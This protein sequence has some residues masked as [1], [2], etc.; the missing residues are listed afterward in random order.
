M[1][2]LDPR[3]SF[4]DSGAVTDTAGAEP[5]EPAGDTAD[6]PTSEA[7]DPGAGDEAPGA[8][9]ETAALRDRVETLASELEALR[10]Q[11]EAIAGGLAQA[12]AAMHSHRLP[13]S[14]VFAGEAVP[15]DRWDVAERLER[16][17]YMSL[18]SP[19][20][21]ILWLKRSARY[22]PYIETELRRAGLPD[23]LKYVAVVESALLPRAYSW[24]HASGIWQFIADTARRYGLRVT[25][26]W[27][28]RR[29]PARSTAA[30]LAYLRDLHA[31]F[32][33]W[34]LALAAYNAGE[35][36]VRGAMSRQGVATY[37]QLA[38][39][40]ETERYFFRILAA[41]LILEDPAQYGFEVPPEERYSPHATEVV[42]LRVVGH[43]TVAEIAAAAG[44][45]YRQ[46][47]ALNP[48]IMADTLPEGRYDVRIPEGRRAGFEAALPG[49]E[50]AMAA[51][52]VQRVR[53]LVKPGDTL[54]GIA[55]RH[56]VSV[57]DIR[58]WNPATRR[59]HIYPGQ[60]ISI[61]RRGRRSR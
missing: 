30:A 52:A 7:E 20:Q 1:A 5:A 50:R 10:E 61:E 9:D 26:S 17:F 47:K 14:I 59:S 40:L 11:M 3:D 22:F 45:F 34:P 6:A 16:E 42:T 60:V 29:D 53:Y 55:R 12:R 54:G 13:E 38:L 36:R 43:V 56:G 19:A 28:E 58:Q 32:K 25:A 51:R 21:V 18:G 41:K 31:S 2:P 15:L 48:A 37:Y 39:P 4:T 35:G 33:E 49:L 23:D 24:A 27:D 46:T 8:E 57:G 44:S